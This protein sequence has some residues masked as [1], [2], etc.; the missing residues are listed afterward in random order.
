MPLWKIEQIDPYFEKEGNHTTLN[1]IGTKLVKDC[2]TNSEIGVIHFRREGESYN[3]VQYSQ[4]T[5]I[6]TTIV[7]S[8]SFAY[9]EQN[10]DGNSYEKAAKALY[11]IYWNNISWWGKLHRWVHKWAL[12]AIPIVLFLVGAVLPYMVGCPCPK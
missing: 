7:D 10:P 6:A 8:A 2:L 1:P 3:E 4:P 11:K 12:P 9:E 5:I